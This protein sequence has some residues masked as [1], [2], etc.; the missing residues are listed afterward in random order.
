[1]K[2]AASGRLRVRVRHTEHGTLE[3]AAAEV[4]APLSI[5]TGGGSSEVVGAA[6]SSTVKEPSP[7]LPLYRPVSFP[8]AASFPGANVHVKPNCV[9]LFP[10]GLPLT[11]CQ[12]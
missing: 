8:V 4:M 1:V 7:R 6:S 12:G 5:P 3:V 2:G 10:T 11:M 9:S